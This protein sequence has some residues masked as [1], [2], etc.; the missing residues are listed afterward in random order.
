MKMQSMSFW[1]MLMR[2]LSTN[3]GWM[4]A[5]DGRQ[6]YPQESHGVALPI[7]A[8]APNADERADHSGPEQSLEKVVSHG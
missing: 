7:Y 2:V 8:N 4:G 1:Q 3:A 6:G 5:S